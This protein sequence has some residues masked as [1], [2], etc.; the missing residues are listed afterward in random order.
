MY[1]FSVMLLYCLVGHSLGIIECYAFMEFFS[2]LSLVLWIFIDSSVI[3]CH[4]RICIVRDR[5]KL[6]VFKRK[7]SKG[8]KNTQLWSNSYKEFLI[9]I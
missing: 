7:E 4:F 9:F 2:L 3:D 5:L 1:L 8:L 6:I